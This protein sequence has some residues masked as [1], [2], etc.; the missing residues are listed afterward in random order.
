[1]SILLLSAVILIFLT[2]I[3]K[4]YNAIARHVKAYKARLAER[5]KAAILA[6]EAEEQARRE[7]SQ[8][9]QT[10]PEENPSSD[11]VGN[12]P[13]SEPNTP[14]HLFVPTPGLTDIDTEL[15]QNDVTNQN[16]ESSTPTDASKISVT[17]TEQDTDSEEIDME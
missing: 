11:P 15:Y 5:H 9:E 7:A 2:Y 17:P 10:K 8:K 6:A 12:G 4:V 16:E 13:S 3:S 1:M 14:E